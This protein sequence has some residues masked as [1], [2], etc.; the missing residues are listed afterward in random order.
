[1][2]SSDAIFDT[3]SLGGMHLIA[4]DENGNLWAY[5]ENSNG[6]L[7]LNDTRY[8]EN[9]TQVTTDINFVS[10]ACGLSYTAAL[11]VDG[12]PARYIWVQREP[13]FLL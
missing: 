9:L 10:V 5:G 13:M 7:G 11:D 1:M 3:A 4:I 2:W 12:Q 8:A 6:C